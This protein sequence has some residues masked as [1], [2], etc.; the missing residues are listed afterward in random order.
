MQAHSSPAADSVQDFIGHCSAL[1]AQVLA[2]DHW[3]MTSRA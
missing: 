1:I 3:T 2:R